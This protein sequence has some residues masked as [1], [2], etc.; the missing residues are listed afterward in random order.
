MNVR[1]GAGLLALLALN[2]C[3]ATQRDMLELGNQ[4]DELKHQ[5][6]DLKTTVTT[7]Q[8]NQ[9]ELAVSMKELLKNLSAFDETIRESQ[10]NMQRL[11]SKL[12]DMSAGISDKV[13]S[14]GET[15]VTQQA[16]IAADQKA[17]S[18]RQAPSELFHDA[19]VR[20]AKK[21][22]DLA[23][24]GFEEYIA[25]HPK[26][27][28]IDVAVYNLGESLYRMNQW[29]SAGK[30]FGLFLDRYP[31]SKLTA[32]GRLMYAMCLVKLKR[33][34]DEAK[35]YLDSIVTDFPS[36]NEAKAAAK[37][38]KKIEEPPPKKKP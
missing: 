1:S 21:D 13:S 6:L 8:S 15:L 12:D 24:K 11:S 30:Q 27:A 38:I 2:G 4:T 29:E 19:E 36:S 3:V 5:V 23:A 9:A 16:K 32:S 25:K 26:G 7:L 17:A 22:F 10:T 14:I 37:E 28:L 18:S 35:Q 33:N 31:K 20:L 34:T